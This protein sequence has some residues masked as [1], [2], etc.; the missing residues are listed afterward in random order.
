[1]PWRGRIRGRCFVDQHV[2]I[3]F[4]VIS[5]KATSEFQAQVVQRQIKDSG[6][7]RRWPHYLRDVLD[8]VDALLM[9]LAEIGPLIPGLNL[10]AEEKVIDI[11][12]S[13][14]FVQRQKLTDCRET[15]AIEHFPE[16]CVSLSVHGG[17]VRPTEVT[18]R[19][20]FATGNS[21]MHQA[22]SSDHINI[23]Q[24]T[25]RTV[26]DLGA[27]GLSP[28]L[29]LGRYRYNSAREPLAPGRHRCLMVLAVPI[30][31]DFYFSVSGITHKVRPGHVIVIRPGEL[32][33][34]GQAAEPRGEL[35]WLITATAE[36]GTV[37]LDLALDALVRTGRPRTWQLPDDA[38]EALDR[39]E[40]IA[41]S[42]DEWLRDELLEHT[43]SGAVL[44]LARSM[45]EAPRPEVEHPRIAQVTKWIDD[46]IAESVSAS[47]LVAMSGL[48]ASQFYAAFRA[49]KGTSAKDYLLRRK[50]DYA[51]DRLNRERDTPV[52]VIAHALGFSSTQQFAT[53]FRRYQGITPSECRNRD[54][55]QPPLCG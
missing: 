39:S 35:L 13:C 6:I 40:A 20:G 1:M 49:A 25:E 48:S 31:G 24:T 2:E 36:S 22:P 46:H 38:R 41:L 50:V 9:A 53:V 27:R 42:D 55:P 7:Q 34:T 52:T 15:I 44:S 3:E 5:N 19:S 16:C 37:G 45:R 12:I 30:R 8:A 4:R 18:L 47:D 32:Y 54:L 26:V 43:L 29:A 23:E 21:T 17:D 33:T 28:L 14:D 11:A 51:R 10:A